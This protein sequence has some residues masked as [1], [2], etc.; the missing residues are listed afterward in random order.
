MKPALTAVLDITLWPV[1]QLTISALILRVPL[2][3]F[4]HDNVLTE[5]SQPRRAARFY[6]HLRVPQWK[7][8][9]PD[10]ASWLGGARKS[11]RSFDVRDSQRFLAETRRAEL[12]HWLQLCCAPVFFLW[13]P[14]WASVVIGVY[15]VA[16]NLP[17]ILAQRYNRAI[18]LQRKP[19]PTRR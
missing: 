4:E 8:H 3:R 13:N 9:L 7:R 19:A 18:L 15:A 5:I 17:C 1:V 6:R 10:G 11:L 16:A 14:R 2:Q 12:A